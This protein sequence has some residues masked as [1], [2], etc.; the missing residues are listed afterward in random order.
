M[1]NEYNNDIQKYLKKEVH[2][3]NRINVS[4]D[5]AFSVVF[6]IPISISTY[7]LPNLHYDGTNLVNQMGYI[8]FA[9]MLLVE[10]LN[11]FSDQKGYLEPGKISLFSI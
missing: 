3:R 6:S 10:K 2:K 1:K 4:I 8:H 7:Y 11:I 5:L 9:K